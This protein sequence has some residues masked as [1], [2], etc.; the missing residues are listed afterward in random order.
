[1]KDYGWKIKISD[2]LRSPGKEDE[3]VFEK[4]FVPDMEGITEEGISGKIIVKALDRYSILVGIE[5]IHTDIDDVSDISGKPY[6][7]HV[8]NP[9]YEALFIIPHEE[10][11]KT[12]GEDETIEHFVINEKDESID[13][14]ECIRNAITIMEPLVKKNEDEK[15]LDSEEIVD[16]DYDQYV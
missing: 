5:N 4:K 16:N 15:M 1:M 2:L 3:I 7:R 14:T 6:T 13:L 8:E 9:F 11:R 10:R 12:K